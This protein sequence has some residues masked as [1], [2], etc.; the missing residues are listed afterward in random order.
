MLSVLSALIILHVDNWMLCH[1][2]QPLEHRSQHVWKPTRFHQIRPLTFLRGDHSDK[3]QSYI[4][5]EDRR[6]FLSITELL[7]EIWWPGPRRIAFH[8]DKLI[9]FLRCL[10]I[11][12][13]NT[14]KGRTLITDSKLVA[15]VKIMKM[16]FCIFKESSKKI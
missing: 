15:F 12:L 4:R 11:A 5:F 14:E 10:H 6:F 8:S 9:F 7:P 13:E 3:T 16:T 1:R 2:R